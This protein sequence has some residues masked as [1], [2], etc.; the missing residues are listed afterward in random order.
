MM[1]T[2]HFDTDIYGNTSG[3]YEGYVTSIGPGDADEVR[4]NPHLN[5]CVFCIISNYQ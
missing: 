4:V 3:R 1:S 2:G 5:V